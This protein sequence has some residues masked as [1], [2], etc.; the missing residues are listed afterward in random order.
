MV[1]APRLPIACSILAGLVLGALALPGCALLGRSI[2][3]PQ[4]T[5][6]DVALVDVSLASMTAGVDLSIMNPN[7]FAVPLARIDWELAV[8]GQAA[9]AGRI[10]L[11]QEIPAKGQAPVTTTIEIRAADAARV[12]PRLLAGDRRYGV[13]ADFHFETRFGELSVTADKSGT[14]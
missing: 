5:M 12:A 13:R 6:Q 9:I 7:A 8:A 11:R 3:K 4:V 2:E 10:D 1:A 14:L